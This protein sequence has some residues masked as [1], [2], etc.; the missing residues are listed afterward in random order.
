VARND[1]VLLDSLLSKAR[2]RFVSG[3]DDSEVLEMF[4]FE[5]LLKDFDLTYEELE[6]GWTDGPEDG[7]VDG[8]FVFV[9]GQLVTEDLLQSVT[10]RNTEIS[11]FLF[12]VRHAEAFQQQPINALC[13]SV[14]E[15]FDLRKSENELSYPFADAVLA[16]RE[17]FRKALVGLADRRPKLTISTYFCGRGDTGTLAENL[18]TRA[19]QLRDS[20]RSFFSDVNAIVEFKGASELLEIARR[21]KTYSLRL[22]FT[23]SYISREGLNYVV[24]A[25]LPDY[26]RFMTDEVGELRRYLF[27]SN[28]RDYL[29]PVRVNEDIMSTLHQNDPS[30][31]EDFWWLNN[32][33]TIL[34]THATVIGKEISLENVQIVNGLQTTETVYKY[35]RNGGSLTDER[36]ILLKVI[37]TSDDATRAR[38]IKATNYQNGV[39]LA[40]LR[41]LDKIQRDIEHFLYDHGWFYDRRKNFYKN[42]GKPADRIVSLPYLA[43]AVRAI[44]LG[45]PARSQRQR[46]RSLRDDGVYTQVFNP[47]WD[48]NVYL[49]SLE[50]TRS[51]EMTLHGRRTILDILPIALVHY[52]GFIYACTR[53]GK[54]NYTPG[55]TAQMVGSAPR[56]EDV[57]KI[58]D[59]VKE[60]ANKAG[61]KGRTRYG[62]IIFDKSYLTRYVSE[63]FGQSHGRT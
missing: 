56:T 9:D 17:L 24:L 14:V 2:S 8:F 45:D 63:R 3:L 54:S 31:A 6:S 11:V 5:H 47:A 53:L 26:F 13:S 18:T 22:R 51:V 44:A 21:D 28:V 37:L 49:A 32:G 1:L 20:V 58:L 40:S 4:C 60:A 19:E 41:G 43:A 39:D 46:S 25:T 27:E 55:E 42:Q 59:E 48:L 10:R 57:T 33:V 50:I 16:Q 7:G 29:G 52:V 15:L 38:I 34:G 30:T 61:I 23:E 62:G 35:F 12:S 36:A